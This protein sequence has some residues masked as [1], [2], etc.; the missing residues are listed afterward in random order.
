MR[1]T[2][3]AQPAEI[4]VDVLDL[5][6]QLGIPNALVG[7]FAVSYCGV[8]RS[9]TDADAVIWLKD[10]ATTEALISSLTSAGY[11][12]KMNSGDIDAPILRA[13]VIEDRHGNRVDLLSGIRGMAP[14]AATRCVSASLL[15]SK[16]H[17]I[18]VEDLIAMK[19]FADGFQDLEDV[20]GILQVSRTL[21]NQELMRKLARR[22]GI[23]VARK[24]D[25]LLKESSETDSRSGDWS[26]QRSIRRDIN[27]TVSGTRGHNFCRP[28][29]HSRRITS[30]R[31]DHRQERGFRGQAKA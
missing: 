3:P 30:R 11:Q 6:T 16:I 4:L 20:R 22:Y 24:L 5:L 31:T 19:V 21:I 12:V 1:T 13:I 17:V 15:D 27:R 9:T 2:G 28:E 10:R 25:G 8:P 7:A 18:A 26:A 29:L 23:A 14:D